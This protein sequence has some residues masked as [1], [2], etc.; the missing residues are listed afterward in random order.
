[1]SRALDAER[2]RPNDGPAVGPVEHCPDVSADLG[3]IGHV[4]TFAPV[5]R[6]ALGYP[7]D[8]FMTGRPYMNGSFPRIHGN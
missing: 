4:Q 7:L 5:H 8:E 2:L 1:M 6:L 3:Q